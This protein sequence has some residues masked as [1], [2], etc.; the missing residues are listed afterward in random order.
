MN[1]GLR[2]LTHRH[3]LRSGLVCQHFAFTCGFSLQGKIPSLG[4]H[5]E[6]DCDPGAEKQKTPLSN[7]L[8]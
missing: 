1:Y 4:L 6:D 7:L 8:S 2:Y 5:F 3:N